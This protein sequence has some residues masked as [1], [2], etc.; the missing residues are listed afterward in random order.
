[1]L[2]KPKKLKKLGQ[3]KR[4]WDNIHHTN[5]ITACITV[6]QEGEKIEKWAENILEDI[7]PKSLPNL[8]KETVTQVQEAQ[9]HKGLTQ[10][11]ID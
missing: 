6:V 4:L 11:G 8:G 5:M 10:R 7:I 2:N 3:F 1:M 9:C